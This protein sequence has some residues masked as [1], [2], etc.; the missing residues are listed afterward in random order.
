MIGILEL[1]NI[2][3]GDLVLLYDR[4]I[5]EKPRKLEIGWLG[6]YIIED[7]SNNGTIILKTLQG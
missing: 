2:S 1:K 6:P 5:K 3:I 4:K 7:L